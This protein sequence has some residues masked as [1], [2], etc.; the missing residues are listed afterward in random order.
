MPPRSALQRDAARADSSPAQSRRRLDSPTDRLTRL[1][2]RLDELLRDVSIGAR[3]HRQHEL[4]V[5]E[6]E[7]IAGELRAVFR[8]PTAERMPLQQS[9]GRAWW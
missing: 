5:A 6:A 4:H 9:G 3:S 7:A 8:A 2:G 1:S